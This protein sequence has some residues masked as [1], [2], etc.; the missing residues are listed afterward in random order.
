[1][2]PHE[3]AMRN[4]G[5]SYFKQAPLE[6]GT[7]AAGGQQLR[8]PA[9]LG[10]AGKGGRKGGGVSALHSSTS[11]ASA[12]D[13]TPFAMVLQAGGARLASS[14][15]AL[16]GGFPLAGG[17]PANLNAKK[18]GVGEEEEHTENNNDEAMGFA[19][20]ED[21]NSLHGDD[22]VVAYSKRPL[23]GKRQ[24]D[25]NNHT[26]SSHGQTQKKPLLARAGRWLSVKA[27]RTIA[28]NEPIV[29]HKTV[30]TT[31]TA[32]GGG[33]EGEKKEDVLLE[34]FPRHNT[35]DAAYLIQ[36]RDHGGYGALY[37]LF[38]AKQR[39]RTLGFIPDVLL[40]PAGRWVDGLHQSF[41]C[42][43][44]DLY[45]PRGV[46]F[47]VSWPLTRALLFAALAMY[48]PPRRADC[49]KV[50]FGLALIAFAYALLV[51]GT[52]PYR[53]P[54]LNFLQMGEG[55][56]L[57][58]YALAPVF[59]WRGVQRKH[60]VTSAPSSTSFSGS[61][62]DKEYLW[63]AADIIFISL[64]STVALGVLCRAVASLAETVLMVRIVR[65]KTSIEWDRFNPPWGWWGAGAGGSRPKS[66]GVRYPL[67]AALQRRAERTD[68]YG[69]DGT[70]NSGP[71]LPSSLA[72]LPLS[73]EPTE[74]AVATGRGIHYGA[75]GGGG[76]NSIGSTSSANHSS[77]R[78]RKD[79]VSFFSS[80]AP[81]ISGGRLMG[82]AAGRVFT[83]ETIFANQKMTLVDYS[84]AAIIGGRSSS[85][86]GG[87]TTASHSSSS[88]PSGGGACDVEEGALEEAAGEDFTV[89]GQDPRRDT[90]RLGAKDRLAFEQRRRRMQRRNEA[91]LKGEA[92]V[93]GN[94]GGPLSSN[95]QS[96]RRL[97]STIGNYSFAN[98]NAEGEDVDEDD[99]GNDDDEDVAGR[100]RKH[101]LISLGAHSGVKSVSRMLFLLKSQHQSQSLHMHPQ[102]SPRGVV[103]S[104]AEA[105]GSAEEWQPPSPPPSV[106]SRIAPYQP[107][108]HQQQQQQEDETYMYSARGTNAVLPFVADESG[109]G[110]G[111]PSPAPASPLAA[112]QSA[113]RRIQPESRFNVV[114]DS[115]AVGPRS[116]VGG[117][118]G[119]PSAV[120]AADD[121]DGSDA[122]HGVFREGGEEGDEEEAT[123]AE[124]EDV[125]V[126][127]LRAVNDNMWF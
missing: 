20:A 33:G 108:Q 11:P 8:G 78:H 76:T 113:K 77:K 44:A 36:P 87:D 29:L 40:L 106:V 43:A 115:D 23:R 126:I 86:R 121:S 57:G 117:W 104:A 5:I 85:R 84:E 49:D 64:I 74:S 101:H 122:H 66:M 59:G 97:S 118:G 58:L 105:D 53:V 95:E 21:G 83:F 42:V 10:L 98:N 26:S 119:W 25:G 13:L 17:T 123:E 6:A 111:K 31:T 82:A 60:N 15:G 96:L 127:D 73:C 55:A 93:V 110:G 1:M 14:S 30:T 63:T 81:S 35:I 37:A 24:G 124:E 109:D 27:G 41:F 46:V 92:S 2:D 7:A 39:V 34:A 16:R 91:W 51:I 54:I 71:P 89:G 22:E 9:G 100:Q 69:G 38:T 70:N 50:H 79:L 112:R 102:Q 52:F 75:S 12:A 125:M 61:W 114:N 80:A 88:N 19:L 47:L 90:A 3:W 4:F 94:G 103:P 99:D 120:A 72:P 48:T 62:G 116:T 45:R 65:M 107:Y 67:T 28:V 32:G 68:T 56:L 18:T